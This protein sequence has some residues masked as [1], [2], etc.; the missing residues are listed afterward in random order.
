M[1]MAMAYTLPGTRA[2]LSTGMVTWQAM[3]DTSNRNLIKDTIYKYQHNTTTCNEELLHNQVTE[4]THV[5]IYTYNHRQAKQYHLKGLQKPLVDNEVVLAGIFHHNLLRIDHK[6]RTSDQQQCK[7]CWASKCTSR[8]TVTC[9]ATRHNSCG[10]KSVFTQWPQAK[11]KALSQTN[12]SNFK[13]HG[14]SSSVAKQTTP[15]KQHFSHVAMCYQLAY[16][17]PVASIT[18]AHTKYFKPKPREASTTNCELQIISQNI[19][20]TSTT[21]Y[22]LHQTSSCNNCQPVLDCCSY[23]CSV[24]QCFCKYVVSETSELGHISNTSCTHRARL[25]QIQYSNIQSKHTCNLWQQ[26][27]HISSTALHQYNHKLIQTAIS[28]P[29][30]RHTCTH[31]KFSVCKVAAQSYSKHTASIRTIAKHAVHCTM[32]KHTTIILASCVAWK[33]N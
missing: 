22:L 27:C 33:H 15:N 26:S 21:T 25:K 10:W 6:R 7:L 11:L 5:L 17:K 31:T 20:H 29:I 28:E 9:Q 8:T 3:H 1:L 2:P 24:I 4:Q 23:W 32:E 16:F 18:L 12:P 19:C 14:V 30:N 13:Q